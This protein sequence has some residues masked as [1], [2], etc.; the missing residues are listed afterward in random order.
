MELNEDGLIP[1]QPVDFD[2]LMRFKAKQREVAQDEKPAEQ[3]KPATRGRKPAAKNDGPALEGQ[4]PSSD[5]TEAEKE[6]R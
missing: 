4:L 5:A 6:S 2:T 3:A 1:G